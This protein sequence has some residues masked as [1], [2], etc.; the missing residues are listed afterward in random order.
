MSKNDLRIKRLIEDIGSPDNDIQIRA[1][2]HLINI[3][4]PVVNALI[5]ATKHENPQVRWRAAY[6]LGKIGDYKAFDAILDLVINPDFRDSVTRYEAFLALGYLG[7][8]RA[9][10]PL[11][12]IVLTSEPGESAIDWASCVLLE[13][14]EQAIE[15]L[16]RIILTGNPDAVQLARDALEIIEDTMTSSI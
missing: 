6:S 9:I 15:V 4:I 7:D 1:E 8:P 14:G 16:R 10:S 3:G 13:F 12:E 5:E 11:A 2:K